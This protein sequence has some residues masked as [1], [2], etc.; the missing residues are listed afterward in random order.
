MLAPTVGQCEHSATNFI[1]SA[2]RVLAVP[3][4]MRELLKR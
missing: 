3:D 2:G 4:R 1:V